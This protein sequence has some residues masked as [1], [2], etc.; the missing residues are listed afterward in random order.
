MTPA[1][2][3]SRVGRELARLPRP[4]APKS[5]APRILAA[6]SQRDREP[7]HRRPWR[8]WPPTS[9]LA[10]GVLCACI[11][12]L[13]IDAWHAIEFVDLPEVVV[14]AGALWRLVV[15]PASVY[16]AALGAAMVLASAACCTALSLMLRQGGPNH[17]A[18]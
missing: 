8:T 3:E 5:L 18:F 7:W 14:A 2:L 1:E 12:W 15:Q 9:K 10:T 13:G 6:I 11:S 16:L 4:R 17:E